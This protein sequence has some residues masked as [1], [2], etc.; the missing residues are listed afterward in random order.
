V[1]RGCYR[2]TG[3]VRATR[4]TEPLEWTTSQGAR[5]RGKIGDWLVR[6][7]PAGRR[8]IDADVFPRLYE[9]VAADLYRAIG[10]VEAR[11]V[12]EPESV[13]TM[14]G[15]VNADPGDWIVSDTAGNM[16]PVP[17]RVFRA[18]YEEIV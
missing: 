15:P 3:I 7:E 12:T 18:T 2:R 4:L 5:L 14:E 16:W 13:T 10:E 17:D 9:W 11:Q 6:S 1:T 8:T